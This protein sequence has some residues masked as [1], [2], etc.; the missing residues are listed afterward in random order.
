[1]QMERTHRR[2]LEAIDLRAGPGRKIRGVIPYNSLSEDLGGFFEKIL[3]GAF[4]DTLTAV[5]RGVKK[6]LSFWSHDA[7]KPLGSTSSGTL[8]LKDTTKGL[9]IEIDP[10]ATS[11][12]KDALE[13]I[14]RGDVTGFSFGFR[15]KEN[16]DRWTEAA[17]K[18]IRELLDVELFEVSPVAAPAYPGSMAAVRARQSTERRMV[19]MNVSDEAR[20]F[21]GTF[22]H[23]KDTGDLAFRHPG[24]FV[25][26]TVR[27]C[28]AGG[29]AYHDPRLIRASGLSAGVASEGGFLVSEQFIMQVI[30]NEY[31][32]VLAPM[33]SKFTLESGEA[34]I[35]RVDESSRVDGSRWGGVA[36]YFIAEGLSMTAT[37]PK[38][39]QC[40]IRLKK[41]VGLCRTT[42]ELLN[43][44]QLLFEFL[45]RAFGAEFGYKI[46]DQIIR[47]TGAGQFTGIL[48]SGTTITVSKEGGQ[49]ADTFTLQNALDMKRR[50]TPWSKTSA[51]WLMNDEVEE[52]LYQMEA[53]SGGGPVFVANH[54]GRPHLLGLPIYYMEQCSKLGD[55]GDVILADMNEYLL[56][57]RGDLKESLSGHL[58][59]TSS[60]SALKLV[61][62]C[63][64]QPALSAPITPANA[65]GT[66][67]RSPFVTLEA[68]A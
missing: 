43:D 14:R 52:Q 33:C 22:Y 28:Q 67:T 4:K 59:F 36:V 51:I 19:D 25:Q 45:R 10:P 48:T 26:A 35:P 39:G 58:Y 6:V 41:L 50:L 2:V 34:P 64:G 61:Y 57:D 65:T 18:T 40:N 47:G 11:W 32:S 42:D 56:C 53:G 46:D 37:K 62:R 15:L 68:R 7:N 55:L 17:G 44:S 16:A 29:T 54:E 30:Y 21:I 13:S 24:E 60:E 31:G 3:P 27:A 23:G 63:D 66:T 1:M 8:K 12:G 49:T 38:F 9:E 20:K 5:K